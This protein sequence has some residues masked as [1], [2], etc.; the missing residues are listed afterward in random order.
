MNKILLFL[1]SFFCLIS[2]LQ[3]ET[4][5][6]VVLPERFKESKVV[7]INTPEY[8][9]LL[10]EN[11]TLK[12]QIDSEAESFNLFKS[13]VD[14]ILREKNKAYIEL[15]KELEKEKTAAKKNLFIARLLGIGVSIFPISAAILG[16]LCFF[17]PGLAMSI[18]SIFNS[19]IGAIF[20][21]IDAI[22]KFF[23]RNNA[24]E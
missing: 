10:E 13:R 23:S 19:I 4:Q 3:S 18:F 5:H 16:V 11:R 17:N 6:Y 15:Q 2:S 1:L 22:I 14:E 20:K 21:W 24:N 9:N 7:V 12:N 8:K